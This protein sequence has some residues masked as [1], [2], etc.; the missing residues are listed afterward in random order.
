MEFT[1]LGVFQ[2]FLAR[3]LK[4]T[5]LTALASTS[6]AAKASHIPDE[7]TTSPSVQGVSVLQTR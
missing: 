3:G 2:F 5:A 1:Q 6:G 4:P 7:R